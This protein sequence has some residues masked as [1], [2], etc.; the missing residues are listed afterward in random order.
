ML[1]TKI[2][3]RHRHVRQFITT[4]FGQNSPTVHLS[5]KSLM[6]ILAEMAS[7]KIGFRH[8]LPK[9]V[10]D[11]TKCIILLYPE[12]LKSHFIHP[13]KASLMAKAFEALFSQ[14][15]LESV[16]SCVRLGYSDYYAV[17]FFMEKYGITEDMVPA[18]TLRKKWRN[19]QYYM[20][21]KLTYLAQAA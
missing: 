14:S 18:D 17:E 8:T 5:K 16:E 7:E 10:V 9:E 19:H 1:K 12:S 20:R 11:D 13:Q 6:G 4:R 3:V 15:F 2:F 21:R